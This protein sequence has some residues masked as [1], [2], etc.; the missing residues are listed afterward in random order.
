[1]IFDEKFRTVLGNLHPD[2]DG[3]IHAEM[4]SSRRQLKGEIE[5]GM[6]YAA[7]MSSGA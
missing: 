1:M 4:P 6:K 2:P 3:E 7:R 5:D